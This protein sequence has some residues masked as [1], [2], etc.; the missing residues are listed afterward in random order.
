[1]SNQFRCG[2]SI[3]ARGKIISAFRFDHANGHSTGSALSR[4]HRPN[5]EPP[6]NPIAGR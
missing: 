6:A 2:V 4:W 5:P 1:L 3:V